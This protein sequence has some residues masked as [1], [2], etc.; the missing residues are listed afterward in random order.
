LFKFQQ[1]LSFLFCFIEKVSQHDKW[2]MFDSS[3]TSTVQ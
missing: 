1:I 3:Q 2:E